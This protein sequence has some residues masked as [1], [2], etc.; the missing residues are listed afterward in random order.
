M[1]KDATVFII[2]ILALFADA[3]G[4]WQILILWQNEK[5]YNESIGGAILTSLVI[6]AICLLWFGYILLRK[7]IDRSLN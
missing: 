1:Q 2:C 5:F 7:I 3:L 4:L 6:L